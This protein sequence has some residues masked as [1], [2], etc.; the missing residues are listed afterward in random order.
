MM[1]NELPRYP[2]FV[3]RGKTGPLLEDYREQEASQVVHPEQVAL[4]VTD[5]DQHVSPMNGNAPFRYVVEYHP[6]GPAAGKGHAERHLATP[7]DLSTST[8]QTAGEGHA[9][10]SRISA[11]D[12]LP[13][14]RP[15]WPSELQGSNCVTSDT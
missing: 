7:A 2:N 6:T 12:S 1:S 14:S 3:M 9:G 4:E 8:L 10:R 15:S 5:H 11:A 13:F